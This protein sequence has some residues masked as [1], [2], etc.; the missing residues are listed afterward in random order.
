VDVILAHWHYKPKSGAGLV[1]LAA[2]K[3]FG[4][5]ADEGS[6][7]TRKARLSDLALNIIL[8]EV[9]SDDWSKLVKQAALA[10][11]IHAELWK[12]FDG[13]LPADGTLKRK[14]ILERSF[15]QS[16]VDE[17][18]PQLRKTLA[19][20]KLTQADK[21]TSNGQDKNVSNRTNEPMS[22]SPPAVTQT[23]ISSNTPAPPKAG[24]L[25]REMSVPI[26]PDEWVMFRAAF[27]LT[28]GKWKQLL[29]TLEAMKPALVKPDETAK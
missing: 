13:S 17:F 10:P 24:Q 12:E 14:L 1:T 27:P 23:E 26:A 29:T 22:A 4:L 8:H 11:S 3:K 5:L 6:G 2:L 20:V 28:E 15:T 25:I 21:L 16:A 9:G 18:V 19:F 7:D